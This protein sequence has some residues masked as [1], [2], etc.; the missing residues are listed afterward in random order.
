M[1][2]SMCMVGGMREGRCADECILFGNVAHVEHCII[3]YYIN[4]CSTREGG[5]TAM[6]HI[7]SGGIVLRY[8]L[9]KHR[10]ANCSPLNKNRAS[11]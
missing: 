4:S 1:C 2:G 6:A 10:R 7:N 5:D 3:N 8:V 9:I 11:A